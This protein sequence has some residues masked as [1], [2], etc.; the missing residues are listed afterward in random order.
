MIRSLARLLQLDR[1]ERRTLYAAALIIPW[2]DLHLSIA[3]LKRTQR[4]LAANAWRPQSPETLAEARMLARM[5]SIAARRGAWRSRCLPTAL[6][7]QWMLARRGIASQLRLGVRRRE[8]LF[9]AHA[10]IE[11]AGEALIDGPRVH[12][13]FAAFTAIPPPGDPA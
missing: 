1:S 5:V 2:M 8:G 11:H 6:A 4:A 9:E 3:G 7:L 13:E 12:D 10:W